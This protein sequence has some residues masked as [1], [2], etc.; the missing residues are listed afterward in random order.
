M[1]RGVSRSLAKRLLAEQSGN[2]SEGPSDDEMRGVMRSE[3]TSRLALSSISTAGISLAVLRINPHVALSILKAAKLYVRVRIIYFD[4]E[5]SH[6]C[7][8]VCNS[9]FQPKQI[10]CIFINF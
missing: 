6:L 8:G 7:V 4:F 3:R 9:V 10:F 2:T 1:Q 5:H